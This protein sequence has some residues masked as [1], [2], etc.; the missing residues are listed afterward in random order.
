MSAERTVS[1]QP[2]SHF[3]ADAPI[4]VDSAGRLDARVRVLDLLAW[5]IFRFHRTSRD[6]ELRRYHTDWRAVL[7][8]SAVFLIPASP[9]RSGSSWGEAHR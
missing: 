1:I 2:V 4:V 7:I 6:I 5:A 9:R 8:V 3:D